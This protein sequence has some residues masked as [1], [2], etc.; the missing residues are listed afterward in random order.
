MEAPSKLDLVVAAVQLTALDWHADMTGAA[1]KAVPIFLSLLKLTDVTCT[2]D[3]AVQTVELTAR[4]RGIP[5]SRTLYWSEIEDFF[6][7]L[8]R[9]SSG[10]AT[11]VTVVT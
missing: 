4:S 11:P 1:I 8:P 3:P 6:Q 5:V 2:I 9:G 7:A 10:S